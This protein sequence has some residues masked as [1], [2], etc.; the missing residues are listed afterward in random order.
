MVLIYKT[1]SPLH[2]RMLCA[3]LVLARWFW[4]RRFLNFVNIFLQFHNYLPQEKGVALYL[5][6]PS[7]QVIYK[8][9]FPFARMICFKFGKFGQMVLKKIFKSLPQR[10]G[11]D[12][13]F[14]QTSI[15]ITQGCFVPSLAEIGPMV[16]EKKMNTL[17]STD[18]W[19]TGD[20]KGQQ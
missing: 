2:Q 19:T 17:Q 1:M 3:K 12:L 9:E 4:R 18:R 11:W 16:L 14:E 15:Q 5:N 7:A 20:Q 13:Q 10:K 8:L 6:K